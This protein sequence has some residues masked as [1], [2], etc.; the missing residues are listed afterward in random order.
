MSPMRLQR[1]RF[2]AAC[3]SCTGSLAGPP[4]RTNVSNVRRCE[5]TFSWN[6]G[7]AIGFLNGPSS[8]GRSN[9]GNELFVPHQ[10]EPRERETHIRRSVFWLPESYCGRLL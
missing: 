8:A 4:R 2:R 6:D 5:I 1:S 3:A 7:L 10:E 9:D